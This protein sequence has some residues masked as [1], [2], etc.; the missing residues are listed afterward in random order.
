MVMV[1]C[2]RLNPKKMSG[3]VCV[4]IPEKFHYIY[5]YCLILYTYTLR[6]LIVSRVQLLSCLLIH[7]VDNIVIFSLLERKLK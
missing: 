2:H 4:S 7:E 6:L 3:T 5:F 1:C